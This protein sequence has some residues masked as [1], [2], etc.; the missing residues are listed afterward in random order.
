MIV[1]DTNVLSEFMNVRPNQAVAAWFD[2]QDIDE[3]WTTVITEAELLIGLA[4][5][6]EGRKKTELR[7]AIEAMLGL[8]ED[9]I[10][11]FDREA[12]QRMPDVFLERRGM[13]LEAKLADSQIAAIALSQGAAVATRDM[14]DFFHTGVK[15][16]NPW[17]V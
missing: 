11:P 10:L 7:T 6:P 12:A 5:M 4:K 14:A 1:L 3:L 9:R 15:I 2:T 13:K 17:T 16:I 8:F